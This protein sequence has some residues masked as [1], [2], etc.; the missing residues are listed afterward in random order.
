MAAIVHDVIDDKL[1]SEWKLSPHDLKQQLLLWEVDTRD[2]RY[3]MDIIT[4]I[5][6]RHRHMKHK[7]VTLEGPLFKMQ[8][9]W[10]R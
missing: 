5:S 4:T 2:I 10:M 1:S 9:D 8:I 3:I 7:P 6:F